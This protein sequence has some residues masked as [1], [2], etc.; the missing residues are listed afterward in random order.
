MLEKLSEHA[1]T[2]RSFNTI[3]KTQRLAGVALFTALAIILNRSPVQFPAPYASFLIYE[4]WEIPIVLA[5]LIFGLPAGI[6]V[7]ILNALILL[8]VFPGSLPSGP[9]YNLAAVVFSLVG[10]SL[11]HKLAFKAGR[12]LKAIAILATGLAI[13]TRVMGMTLINGI[14][15]SFPPPVGFYLPHAVVY[16][17]LP[18]IAFF[19]GTVVLYSV[20]LAYSVV[21]GISSK[22]GGLRLAYAVPTRRAQYYSR[23]HTGTGSNLK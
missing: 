13:V 7:G 19:N 10:V 8:A 5:L 3:P 17:M 23:Q 9:L 21:R 18:A 4:V 15:L 22:H 14:F 2:R 16:A 20:P 12:S 11:G 6:T 1:R